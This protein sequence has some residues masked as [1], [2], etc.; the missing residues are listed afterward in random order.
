MNIDPIEVPLPTRGLEPGLTTEHDQVIT[1]EQEPLESNSD[2]FEVLKKLESIDVDYK[3]SDDK[4]FHGSYERIVPNNLKHF[5]QAFHRLN[6]EECIESVE[7][8]IMWKGSGGYDVVLYRYCGWEHDNYIW[9]FFPSSVTIGSEDWKI[10]KRVD[11]DQMQVEAY[12]SRQME[13]RQELSY[14][15]SQERDEL[16]IDTEL[17]HQSSRKQENFRVL[18][19]NKALMQASEATVARLQNEMRVESDSRL[20]IQTDSVD[21]M[22]FIQE[23]AAISRE[24]MRCEDEL[25]RENMEHQHALNKLQRELTQEQS[26][27]L[28]HQQQKHQQIVDLAALQQRLETNKNIFNEDLQKAYQDVPALR[29][30]NE[31]QTKMIAEQHTKYEEERTLREEKMKQKEED[32]AGTKAARDTLQ[33]QLQKSESQKLDERREF[34]QHQSTAERTMMESKVLLIR[35]SLVQKNHLEREAITQ[36]MKLSEEIVSLK[37]QNAIDVERANNMEEKSKMKEKQWEKEK[38]ILERKWDKLVQEKTALTEKVTDLGSDLEAAKGKIGELKTGMSE[39]QRMIK[40]QQ[41]Q[42]DEQQKQKGVVDELVIALESQKKT[43]EENKEGVEEDLKASKHCVETL[44]AEVENAKRRE[45]EQEDDLATER[46]ERSDTEQELHRKSEEHNHQLMMVTCIGG[47]ISLVIGIIITAS[48]W[49]TLA[50]PVVPVNSPE[51]TENPAVTDLP[52]IETRWEIPAED[53]RA[54]TIEVVTD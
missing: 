10:V 6:P 4:Q 37:L 27:N 40:D 41:A 30:E 52:E 51:V 17:M 54:L 28:D 43:L 26:Q 45:A 24:C 21:G 14:D 49:R 19:E 5:F 50:P 3:I 12:N 16:S 46:R 35:H 32:H 20:A 39:R 18:Q 33:I 34:R 23:M 25:S 1:T 38:E 53:E 22:K 13:I 31:Q 2:P 9:W 36:D 42:M 47:G 8:S 7:N 48:V 15:E 11:F 29:L 44:Q